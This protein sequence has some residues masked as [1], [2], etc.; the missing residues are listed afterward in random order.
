VW[1]KSEIS[2]SMLMAI[3]LQKGLKKELCL[4]KYTV[5]Q[6]QFFLLEHLNAKVLNSTKY[7]AAGWLGRC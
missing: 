5:N 4:H 7:I 6:S 2:P 1:R 3:Y